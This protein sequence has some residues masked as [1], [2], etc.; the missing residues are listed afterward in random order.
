[1]SVVSLD[2]LP[3]F[4]FQS[5]YKERTGER[6]EGEREEEGRGKG[7]Q[8]S[9]GADAPEKLAKLKVRSGKKERGIAGS[10]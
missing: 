6:E 10:E 7:R 5:G 1:M 9:D 8:S 2:V 3:F 4:M